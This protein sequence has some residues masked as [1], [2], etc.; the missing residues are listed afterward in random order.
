MGGTD[1]PQ[2]MPQAIGPM[3]RVMGFTLMAAGGYLVAR[4]CWLSAFRW[5]QLAPNTFAPLPAQT[6]RR[7]GRPC[8]WVCL[9]IWT[10]NRP[11]Y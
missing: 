8:H 1:S 7:G 10:R 11:F 2:A 4:A 3:R 9:W 5:H 6:G